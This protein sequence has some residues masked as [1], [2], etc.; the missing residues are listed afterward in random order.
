VAP[1]RAGEG[2]GGRASPRP[3]S[4][5]RT[6]RACSPGPDTLRAWGCSGWAFWRDV[7]L[8]CVF[9]G[10][11][12]SERKPR[13]SVA[14]CPLEACCRN[15]PIIQSSWCSAAPANSPAPTKHR[16]SAHNEVATPFQTLGKEA[17][18]IR[19][20]FAASAHSSTSL[21]RNVVGCVASTC[22]VRPVLVRW[23]GPIP[24]LTL[25]ELRRWAASPRLGFPVLGAL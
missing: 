1:V 17:P 5:S 16:R 2:S 7:T 6:Y 21:P 14:V 8:I 24:T 18:S 20:W 4:A 15:A 9:A 11:K 23:D 22:H 25:G 12:C 13:R 10:P 3:Q 19:A